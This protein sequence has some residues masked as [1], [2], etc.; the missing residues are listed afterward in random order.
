VVG[1]NGRKLEERAKIRKKDE[2]KKAED[3]N[4]HFQY[5]E[6]THLIINKNKI[7]ILTIL[8]LH[9]RSSISIVHT[10]PYR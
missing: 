10:S 1:K 2:K 4:K 3:A 9:E 6:A 8:I 7:N 5:C